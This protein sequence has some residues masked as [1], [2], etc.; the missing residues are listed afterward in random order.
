MTQFFAKAAD[1]SRL[2]P[3]EPPIQ[4]S[5]SSTPLLDGVKLLVQPTGSFKSVYF[6]NVPADH[7]GP[8]RFERAGQRELAGFVRN[9]RAPINLID[10]GVLPTRLTLDAFSALKGS[11]G[12]TDDDEDE[13]LL[14]R[15]YDR[16]F[17]TQEPTIET[18][19]LDDYEPFP[20][21]LTMSVDDLEDPAGLWR[22]NPAYLVFGHQFGP[23]LPGELVVRHEDFGQA[24]KALLKPGVQVWDHKFRDG[25][26]DG[27]FSIGYSDN[28]T[29]LYT[30]PKEGRRKQ[31]PSRK[32]VSQHRVDFAYPIP[33]SFK[34]ANLQQA[35]EAYDIAVLE[36]ADAINKP[37]SLVVCGHCDGTGYVQKES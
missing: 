37:R 10:S 5:G 17:T 25:V 14:E 19:S 18:I 36:I 21:D 23:A 22:V 32:I 24:V 2:Y 33:E 11:F 12:F 6:L 31:P 4:F 7:K 28:R 3:F 16:E 8:V 1:G 34:A 20:L 29:H 27:H 13:W 30:P 9:G 35:N 15:W 26:I